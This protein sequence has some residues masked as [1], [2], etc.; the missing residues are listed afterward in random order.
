MHLCQRGRQ[1]ARVGVGKQEVQMGVE[2][3]TEP[4][5]QRG[6]QIRRGEILTVAVREPHVVGFLLVLAG[7]DQVAV[8][9]VQTGSAD[10][11]GRRHLQHPM[12]LTNVL[13][14]GPALFVHPQAHGFDRR[15]VTPDVV[16]LAHQVFAFGPAEQEQQRGAAVVSVLPSMALEWQVQRMR[17][18]VHSSRPAML[19]SLGKASRHTASRGLRLADVGTG[20]PAVRDGSTGGGSVRDSWGDVS[21]IAL[22]AGC[23]GFSRMATTK[24]PHSPGAF[25]SV[26]GTIVCGTGK[27]R[28]IRRCSMVIHA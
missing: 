20:S 26:T 4:C 10:L 8:L 5:H 25:P 19:S 14:A 2:I 18:L 23:Q 17:R 27:N 1:I 11:P 7:S 15:I 3:P 16:I 9:I 6:H 24:P 28:P 13:D 21:F 22:T 12:Q